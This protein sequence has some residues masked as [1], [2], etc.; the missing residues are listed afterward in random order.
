[1]LGIWV[2]SMGTTFITYNIAEITW[3]CSIVDGWSGGSTVALL[4]CQASW[5]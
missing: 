1:M 2:G 5:Q 4:T 3:H